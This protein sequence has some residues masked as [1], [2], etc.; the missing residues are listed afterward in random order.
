MKP[1]RTQFPDDADGYRK[2]LQA[3]LEWHK[4]QAVLGNL[5]SRYERPENK[6]K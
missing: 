3:V 1:E 5:K 4:E 2:Y 6:R